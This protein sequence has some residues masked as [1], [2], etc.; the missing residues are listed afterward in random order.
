[1]RGSKDFSREEIKKGHTSNAG[2]GL[3]EVVVASAIGLIIIYG[4]SG[5]LGRF[6]STQKDLNLRTELTEQ[7]KNIRLRAD[8][9]ASL[10]GIDFSTVPAAGQPIELKSYPSGATMIGLNGSTLDDKFSFL[11]D[12][13][14]D[15]T[16]SIR[17]ALLASP[18]SNPRS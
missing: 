5:A 9:S 3:I 11:A 8:C 18:S 12:V 4:I 13:K 14:P 6:Y 16:I 10:A 2:M 1:M 17:A 7:L 15:R